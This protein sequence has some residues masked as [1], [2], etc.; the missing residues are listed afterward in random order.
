MSP[1]TTVNAETA[2]L[3]ELTMSA[4]T[5]SQSKDAGSVCSAFVVVA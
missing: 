3:G 5:L 2:W 4:L 1:F